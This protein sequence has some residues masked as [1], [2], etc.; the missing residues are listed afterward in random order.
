VSLPTVGRTR[1]MALPHKCMC[2]C[3]RSPATNLSV[4]DHWI[5]QDPAVFHHHVIHDLYEPGFR[6]DC[7]QGSVDRVAERAA[8]VTRAIAGRHLQSTWVDIG[9]QMLRFEVPR[10][11]HFAEGDAAGGPLNASVPNRHGG[12][13]GLQ[14]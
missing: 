7:N 1:Q 11:R 8:V 5:D 2:R 4:H 14:Q 9:R 12:G 13:I 3:P 10:A 6:I